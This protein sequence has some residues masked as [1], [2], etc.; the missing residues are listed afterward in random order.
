MARTR[1][2]RYFTQQVGN[3]PP[4]EAVIVRITIDQRLVWLPEGEWELRFPTVIGPRYIGSADRAEDARDARQGHRSAAD[5]E[6]S[7]RARDPR[8]DRCGREA[9]FAI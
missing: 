5:R 3:I 7:D 8:C 1:A 6:D 2:R 9:E 4:R